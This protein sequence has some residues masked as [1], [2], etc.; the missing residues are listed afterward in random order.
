VLSGGAARGAFE[1][2]VA[3][4]LLEEEDFDVVCGTS[5][6]AMNGAAVALGRPD[7][8]R[9][10]WGSIAQRG[11]VRPAPELAKAQRALDDGKALLK[12]PL[13]SRTAAL[14]RLAHDLFDLPSPKGLF[15]I[16]GLLTPDPVADIL[17]PHLRLEELV[18]S[19]VIAVTN[20]SKGTSEAFYAF[21]GAGLEHEAAFVASEPGSQPLTDENV[22]DAVRASAALPAAYAP[23]PIR[24]A[25]GDLDEYADGAIANNTPL[26]QAID[27]GA[28]EIT[29][30]F[31]Q[32]TALRYR[33]YRLAN[34]AQIGF[35]SHDITQQRVLDLDLKLARSINESI[36]RG[37]GPTGKRYVEL[38]A[39]APSVP[40]RL[41][42]LSFHDQASVD[43]VFAQG[44]AEGRAALLVSRRSKA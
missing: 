21:R 35:V 30:I 29:L 37:Q 27:A 9:E 19:F 7:L 36:R 23:I 34:I 10:I 16:R 14:G 28:D 4:A 43:R 15:G 17:R 42:A 5:V 3:S 12:G 26:R 32:H 33:D 2:G 25:N 24:S 40:L 18:R 39:I 31:M 8:L 44:V 1:A 6:G 22:F 41:G 38:R 20:L 13:G 11:I